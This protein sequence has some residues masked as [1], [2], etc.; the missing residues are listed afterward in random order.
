L[1]RKNPAAVASG[2]GF[3]KETVTVIEQQ[4]LTKQP[5]QASTTF[6]DSEVFPTGLRVRSRRVMSGIRRRSVQVWFE[7]ETAEGRTLT[8]WPTRKV[9]MRHAAGVPVVQRQFG[10]AWWLWRGERAE[11]FVTKEAA[12]AARKRK[13]KGVA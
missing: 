5:T 7:V 13:Q 6:P 9:A 11:V 4:N 2:A 12:A 3:G 1:K 10:G 8:T